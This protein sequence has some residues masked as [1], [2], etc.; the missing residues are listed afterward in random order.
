MITL[1]ESDGKFKNFESLKEMAEYLLKTGYRYI[2]K[3]SEL[4]K[5]AQEEYDNLP[6]LRI[7]KAG[8]VQV[9]VEG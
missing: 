3:R 1:K 5:K 7:T 9:I 4:P 8:Y 2:K 6:A